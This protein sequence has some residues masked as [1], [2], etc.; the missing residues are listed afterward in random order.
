MRF[1]DTPL[2]VYVCVCGARARHHF[3]LMPA[4][5]CSDTRRL[6]YQFKTLTPTQL[7]SF[8]CTINTAF[9]YRNNQN[10]YRKKSVTNDAWHLNLVVRD[11]CQSNLHW[12]PNEIGIKE[13]IVC[14]D[15]VV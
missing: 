4:Y 10:W 14:N 12:L 15:L 3:S 5:G 8:Y 2:C 11:S 9:N 13:V 6:T 1:L 7:L